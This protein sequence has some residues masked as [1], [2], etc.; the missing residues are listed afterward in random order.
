MPIRKIEYRRPW[1]AD[2]QREAL[3]GPERYAVIEG[4]TKCGKTAPCLVW[5]AEQAMASQEGRNHWWVAPVY[6]QAEIAYRRM[7]R[8]LPR[9]LY[10]SQDQERW[11]ELANGARMWFKSAEKPDNLYGE[12]VY[13]AVIDEASRCREES[14]HAVRSTLTAT[15]GS[16][17]I[18]GNVKGRKNWAYRMARQAE[19]G[20]EGMTFRKITAF[21]AIQAGILSA[22]EVE[23][24]RRD[25]PEAV[26]R[27]LYLAE[28]S[29]DEGNPFN[30]KSVRENIR[31]LSSRAPV[32]W[33]WDLAK[34]V[35]WTVGIALDEDGAVCRFERFQKPWTETV[36]A[37]VRL[38]G[39]T[40]AIVD[41]TG[42]GDPIVE[43]LQKT[44]PNYE[45]FK[46]T[47][48]SKQ[49]LM[50]GLAV[51]IQRGDVA[52]PDGPIVHELEAFEYVYTR[53]G[54]RY[55]APEGMHDDCVMALALAKSRHKKGTMPVSV[56]TVVV[57]SFVLPAHWPRVYAL[58]VGPERVAVV[59]GAIDEAGDVLYAYQ[60]HIGALSAP[61]LHGPAIRSRGDW[62]RGIVDPT[63][64]KRQRDDM[65]MFL[66]TWR[67]L[68]L[69]LRPVDD[70]GEAGHVALA[71]RLATGRLKIMDTLHATSA[72]YSAYR[73]DDAG[74]LVADPLMDCLRLLA[75]V[76][77]RFATLQHTTARPRRAAR[78]S[79]LGGY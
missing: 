2:Y 45:G 32:V 61:S 48:P 1:L 10:R 39:E 13:S 58:D 56:S 3:F 4:S 50:E 76:G 29:D 60:E 37:I 36:D 22:D 24:A 20:A 27:E 17:R 15:R 35:D 34:S 14:W 64:H 40:H 46:F 11:I 41:S 59:W 55:S 62:L 19:A 21:D 67:G 28:P 9:E 63:A 77:P 75:S 38:T 25:L 6:S 26:F 43:S 53:T 23:A 12:D 42:V 68:G 33:G 54:V 16:V 47:G 78:T 7:K 79:P 70:P 74:K 31:P 30:I 73:R 52:Y 66:A 8:G 44:G 69:K 71:E 49:Q 57:P 72:A 51:A 5:L 65:A 18:I